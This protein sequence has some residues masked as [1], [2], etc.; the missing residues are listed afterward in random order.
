MSRFFRL[1]DYLWIKGSD[2]HPAGSGFCEGC[3]LYA[4]ALYWP[5]NEEGNAAR[6]LCERCTAKALCELCRGTGRLG[7]GVCP[8][9]EVPS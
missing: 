5:P 7:E 4:N 8:D 3:D 6:A 9:C 2:L 1:P